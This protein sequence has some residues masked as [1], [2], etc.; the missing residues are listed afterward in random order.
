MRAV[1]TVLI[2]VVAASG[3]ASGIAQAAGTSSLELPQAS[4][5]RAA[6]SSR[7]WMAQR[8]GRQS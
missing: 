2:F 1:R 6:Y 8:I 4:L 7:L 3:G 5:V